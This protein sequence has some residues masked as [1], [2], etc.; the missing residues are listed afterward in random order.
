MRLLQDSFEEQLKEL[1]RQWLNEMLSRKFAEEGVNI[2][3]RQREELAEMILSNRRDHLEGDIEQ[4]LK[5]R[6]LNL[7]FTAEDSAWLDTRWDR[8]V[9]ELPDIYQKQADLLSTTVLREL[10]R[11]WP[12]QW[13]SLRRLV[14][15]FRSRLFKRWRLGLGQLRMLQTI[16]REYGEGVIYTVQRDGEVEHPKMFEALIKLHIRAC[17]VTDEILCLLEGGF[18][19]GAMARWRTLNEIAGVAYL[20]RKHGEELAERYLDHDVVESYKASVQYQKHYERLKHEAPDPKELKVVADAYQALIAKYGPEF[21]TPQGWAA[22]HL[23]KARPSIA[24]IQ[25]GSGIDHLGPY[26]KIA[27]QAVHA[28]AKAL[29]FK[30]GGLRDARALNAG[31]SNAGLTDPGH[32]T[33]ISL[34]QISSA[35][36]EFAPTLD[37]IVLM[38]IMQQ[39]ETEIGHSLLAAQVQLEDDEVEFLRSQVEANRSLAPAEPAGI[40]EAK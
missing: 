2:A 32:S 34:I 39:L 23:K 24:D 21:G 17:Q 6:S 26:Y 36:M 1:P 22:K 30:L 18:A 11:R 4:W 16:A 15:G 8:H 19:D 7:E 14:D 13:R 29:S 40:A 20:I 28:S 12:R 5:S 31:P 35:L 38:K 9:A 33:A 27:S 3:E 25:E 37:S 10:E